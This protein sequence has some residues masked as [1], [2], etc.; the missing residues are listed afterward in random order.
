[1][2]S[3]LVGESYTY[4]QMVKYL[5]LKGGDSKMAQIKQ[6]EREYRLQKEGIRYNVL[7]KYKEIKPKPQKA[8]SSK[9]NQ[10]FLNILTFTALYPQFSIESA[11][12]CGNSFHFDFMHTSLYQFL[13]FPE[14]L[15]KRKET[16]PAT[17]KLFEDEL[18]L[19][20]VICIIKIPI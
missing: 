13:G 12:D 20:T 17:S 11:Q 15:H 10:L 1:M 3:L 4:A 8:M 9:F 2:S 19:L 18:C 14:H 6:I 5:P 16:Y 7:G